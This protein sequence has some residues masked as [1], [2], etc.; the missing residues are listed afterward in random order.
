MQSFSFL[1]SF[2]PLAPLSLSSGGELRHTLDLRAYGADST[3][4]AWPPRVI[5]PLGVTRKTWGWAGDELRSEGGG[6]SRGRA[7]AGKR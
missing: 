5:Q 3:G 4:V 7:G 1:A 6:R 2:Q